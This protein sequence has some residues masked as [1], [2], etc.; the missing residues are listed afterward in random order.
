MT[1]SIRRQDFELLLD[2]HREL[3]RLTNELEF[4]LYRLGEAA[5]P[6]HVS[7]CQQTAGNL[8]GLLR[9]N[10]FRHDQEVLPVLESLIDGIN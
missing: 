3:I 2:E 10:L 6:E 8:V 9:T 5:T 4:Q 1:S 7:E